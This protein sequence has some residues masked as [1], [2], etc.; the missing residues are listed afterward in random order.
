MGAPEGAR[1][2]QRASEYYYDLLHPDGGP[3]PPG[4]RQHVAGCTFCQERM[5]R[6]GAI[7]R[8]SQRQAS[9][10]A[11]QAR[12]QTI[13]T[14]RRHFDRLN[15]PVTCAHARPFLA[16]L[17]GASPQ[18]RISTP[19]TAHLDRC[20]PCARDLAALRALDLTADQLERLSQVYSASGRESPNEC[21]DAR[22][23][24]AALAA[25]SLERL[26]ARILGHI[27]TCSRCRDEL[28]RQRERL[29]RGDRRE[30]A[31]RPALSCDDVT[32][33]DLFDLVVPDDAPAAADQAEHV[34]SCSRCLERV[35]ALHRTVYGIAERPDSGIVTVYDAVEGVR[36]VGEASGDG[37][38]CDPSGA[39][40]GSGRKSPAAA[41]ATLRCGCIG[42]DRRSFVKIALAAVGV[43]VLS[44]FFFKNAPTASGT[45][46][47]AVLQALEQ[48]P[49]LH[50]ISL[51]RHS[52]EPVQETWVARDLNVLILKTR[53]RHVLYD[54]KGGRKIMMD[55]NLGAG[56]P[57]RLS[58]EE[59]Q[60]SRSL[61]AG[62]VGGLL[63]TVS[64][65]A[66][67]HPVARAP[68]E[69]EGLIVYE[70]TAETHGY[71]GPAL[72]CR[73]RVSID[74]ATGLPQKI[75]FYLREPHT[76]AWQ[77]QSARGFEYLT[78]QAMK[79]VLE[80]L[81]PKK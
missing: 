81:E 38:Y 3:V 30:A 59:Y 50:I 25:L 68:G 29:P 16:G 74:P 14:L 56:A 55:P 54:L 26:D 19:I 21:R 1:H 36:V 18:V 80:A 22:P 42:L 23:A 71:R 77:L 46:V 65:S 60:G 4:I 48:A 33:A 11:A 28:Y 20:P 51:G 2:C 78:E 32:P 15:E 73:L 34:R 31:D 27:R 57:T 40:V 72:P 43:S 17:L 10:P 35:Q 76:D 44:T 13:E 7:L 45:N 62:C 52:P 5:R 69:P 61:V 75:E 6:L 58:E 63:A 12:E 47:G 49:N 67:L 64:R 66:E 41:A 24:V 39:P 37:S 9:P 53:D 70:L 8:E 79:D